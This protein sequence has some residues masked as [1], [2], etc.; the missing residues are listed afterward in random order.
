MKPWLFAGLV[1]AFAFTSASCERVALA[2]PA[3]PLVPTAVAG[4]DRTVP[5]G[6]GVM[7]DGGA[8][9]HPGGKSLTFQW[10]F[11]ARPA[12]SGA[13]ISDSTRP[14]A[15]FMPDVAGRYQVRLTVWADGLSDSSTLE[16]EVED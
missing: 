4:E 15:A 8:S 2:D 9:T 13:G 6:V 14:Q 12:M 5:L 7:L 3:A 1:V 11:D 10:S 16:V